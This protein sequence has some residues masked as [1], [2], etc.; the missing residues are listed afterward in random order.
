[1]KNKLVA[2]LLAAGATL[3]A[4]AVCSHSSTSNVVDKAASCSQSGVYHLVCDYC[5]ETVES[6]LAIALLG[7]DYRLNGHLDPTSTDDGYDVYLCFKCGD[8][9]QVSMP[10]LSPGD[11]KPGFAG[12]HYEVEESGTV[13]IFVNRSERSR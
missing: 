9:Y 6:G 2:M 12:Q 11:A 10:K 7:H 5:G 13:D 3:G 4:W 1:M 8:S